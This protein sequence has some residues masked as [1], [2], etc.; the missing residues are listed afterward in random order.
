M[1]PFSLLALASLASAAAV[2]DVTN[3]AK[4]EAETGIL[5]GV[6]VGNNPGG[7]SGSGFVQG[8]D[9]A[10]DSVTITFQSAKQALYDVIIQYASTSGEKQTTMSLNDSGGSGIVL[11]ATSEE[12][13][14]ANATAGQVLLKAG[15]NTITFT[16]NWGWYFIDAVYVSPSAPPAKHQVTSKLATSNPLPI[17]Q[18]LFN[19]LLSNYG[20]GSIFSGQSEAAGIAWLEENVGK[21]P[22]IIGL[23]FMDYSPSRVEHGT[24]SNEVEDGI[25]FSD[26]NGI[27]AFQWH[28]NAPSHLI[29]SPAEPWY[30]GFYTA[31][32]T[33]NLTTVLANPSS[34]DYAL[35][36]RDLDTIAALLL[37]LQAANVPVLWRPLH[38]AEGGWFWWGAQ[39]PEACVALYR[40]MFDRFTNHHQL[41]NLI[42]VWNSVATAWYPGDDMVDILGYDSYPPAGDH[43]A[44]SAPYQSLITLG[45]DRKM[46]SLPEVGNIPDPDQLKLYQADW[47]YFVTWNG[48]YIDTDEFNSLDFKKKVFNN[49]S[50][51]NLSDLGN[52][53]SN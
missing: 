52:W 7:F 31:A 39:G 48:A 50:V 35:L 6:T 5:N 28:W 29:D 16:S 18:T 17:T 41:R 49:P 36:I 22:A 47:S 11:G 44:V 19:K 24:T 43:G 14:W 9:A 3:G 51:I 2:V 46:V 45:K 23:D 30:S 53:K 26:R 27:V 33:F 15:T 25:A 34:A 21:T 32:T 20:N 13:P 1:R 37:R 8:F 40:L 10:S 4:V 42:W 38:E 12:S